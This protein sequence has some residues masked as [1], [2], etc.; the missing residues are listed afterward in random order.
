[1][2]QA[3]VSED[4]F[5][6]SVASLELFDFDLP[7]LR[8]RAC[9]INISDLILARPQTIDIDEPLKDLLDVVVST[10]DSSMLVVEDGDIVGVLRVS[11]LLD[12]VI[13]ASLGEGS[14]ECSED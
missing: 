13:K 1:M 5:E 14:G 7:N 10:S 3:G 8:D 11:D 2:R 6:S 4:M 12:E 9:S